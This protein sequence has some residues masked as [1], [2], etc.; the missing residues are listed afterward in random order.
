MKKIA[1]MVINIYFIYFFLQKGTLPMQRTC[2]IPCD[3][4]IYA[5]IQLI[6][7]EH[8]CKNCFDCDNLERA[9]LYY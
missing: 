4:D 8:A 7:V 6:L 3:M 9:L 1:G 2:H 5:I